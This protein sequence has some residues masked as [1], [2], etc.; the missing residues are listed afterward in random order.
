MDLKQL[1]ADQFSCEA[2]KLENDVEELQASIREKEA[3]LADVEEDS[4]LLAGYLKACVGGSDLAKVLADNPGTIAPVDTRDQVTMLRCSSFA[5][6]HTMS[7][8]MVQGF[9]DVHGRHMTTAEMNI[10]IMRIMEVQGVVVERNVTRN[11]ITLYTILASIARARLKG[12]CTP[13]KCRCSTFISIPR[14]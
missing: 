9:V 14:T 10:A 4:V 11:W 8:L 6:L 1:E 12:A 13:P 5:L 3:E 2:D 7:F